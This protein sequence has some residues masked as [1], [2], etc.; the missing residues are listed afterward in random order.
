[1]PIVW[2]TWYIYSLSFS[3]SPLDIFS[4]I[5]SVRV[6]VCASLFWMICSYDVSSCWNILQWK[7]ETYYE[8]I[9]IVSLTNIIIC[10]QDLHFIEL[11]CECVAFCRRYGVRCVAHILVFHSSFIALQFYRN[12]WTSE[13]LRLPLRANLFSEIMCYESIWMRS[14]CAPKP[15]LIIN[16]SNCRRFVNLQIGSEW[17]Y[18][19]FVESWWL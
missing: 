15:I 19:L 13:Y 18:S 1:M 8:V 10:P 4:S 14:S 16:L 6:C 12:R 5:S 2:R 17:N 9:Y 3:V 7:S 11:L